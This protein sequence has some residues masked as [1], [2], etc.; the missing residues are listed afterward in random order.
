MLNSSVKWRREKV[1][2]AKSGGE[3]ELI[4]ILSCSEVGKEGDGFIEVAYEVRC[5]DLPQPIEQ[6]ELALIFKLYV[7]PKGEAAH[8][9]EQYEWP[10]QKCIPNCDGTL[11]LCWEEQ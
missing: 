7:E 2:V 10:V 4:P 11:M 5:K 6:Y 9:I 3:E 1:V 8:C